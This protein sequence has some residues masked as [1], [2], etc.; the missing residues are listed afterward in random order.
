MASR[1]PFR[2]RTCY[3]TIT[4][5]RG[6]STTANWPEPHQRRRHV[7]VPR[8]RHHRVHRCGARRHPEGLG[9]H[10]ELPRCACRG[11]RVPARPPGR[12]AQQ[13]DVRERHPELR[14]AVIVAKAIYAHLY[15]V[16]T[17]RGSTRSGTATV[18]PPGWWSSQASP[19]AAWCRPLHWPHVAYVLRA[20]SLWGRPSPG[21]GTYVLHSY[22]DRSSM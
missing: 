5:S 21:P 14:F 2:P 15:L 16:Y 19:T 20:R 18:A 10:R 22:V 6:T 12:V 9:R 4:T 3:R 1:M 7:A 13:L 8:V 17:S 11:L